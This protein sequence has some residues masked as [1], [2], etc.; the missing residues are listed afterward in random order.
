MEELEMK[1]DSNGNSLVFLLAGF[2]LGALI[3]AAAG[4]AFAPKAGNELRNE[5]GGK[6]KELTGKT[7]GWIAEQRAKSA[8]AAI[9]PAEEVGA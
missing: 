3:G 1:N 2:G 9:P 6:V 4:L 7:Q 8:N 5:V